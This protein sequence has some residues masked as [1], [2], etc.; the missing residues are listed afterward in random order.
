MEKGQRDEGVNCVGGELIKLIKLSESDDVEAYLMTFEKMME[1][2]QVEKSK[3]A[4]LLAPQLNG[5][6]QQ[7][8]A[9]MAGDEAGDYDNLKD[10]ILRRY[11]I[12]GKVI[13]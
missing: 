11:N 13:G 6:A 1:A 3:W 10:A 9:A 2:Y 4:Y 8:N 5:K 7:A 12:N